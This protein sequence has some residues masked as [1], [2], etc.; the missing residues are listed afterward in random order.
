MRNGAPAIPLQTG[1]YA[2]FKEAPRPAKEVRPRSA[3]YFHERLCICLL[4]A[5]VLENC[6]LAAVNSLLFPVSQGL[7]VGA[8]LFLTASAIGLIVSGK[9]RLERP[10]MFG[11]VGFTLCVLAAVAHSGT[12]DTR[13]LYDAT[14]IPIF[15]LLGMTARKFSTSFLTAL[16]LI[17][18]GVAIFELIFP[19]MYVALFNPLRYFLATRKWM[20]E[21]Q[22]LTATIVT[23]NDFYF[24]AHRPGGT[25][26]GADHRVGSIFLEPLSLGYFSFICAIFYL[27]KFR[28]KIIK[29][30]IPVG[31]CLALAAMSDSR[32]SV[33]LIAFTTLFRGVIGRSAAEI[34]YMSPILIL[35]VIIGVYSMAQTDSGDLAYRLSLTFGALRDASLTDILFGGQFNTVLGDSGVIYM[36]ANAGVIGF[37]LYL[38]LASGFLVERNSAAFVTQAVLLY[39]VVASLFGGAIFS[40]KTA[41]ILGF[42]IGSAVA[43]ARGPESKKADKRAGPLFSRG[44]FGLQSRSGHG[45]NVRLNPLKT[46]QG[47]ERA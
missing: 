31:V 11:C 1:R 44:P 3:T 37:F 6:V 20:G 18:L 42:G 43:N 2:R 23:A 32:T 45:Q 21:T 35:A 14:V 5:C 22:G 27:Y 41:A 19:E 38:F 39:L 30:L 10:F 28:H 13:F 15:I 4:Y 33:F 9:A 40:I 16:L 36:I 47:P 34:R 29:S 12:V 25:I 24:G 8:Q 17:V 46:K 26:F 7:V